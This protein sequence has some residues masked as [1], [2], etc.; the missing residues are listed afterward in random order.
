MK[1]RVYLAG[2]ALSVAA[3]AAHADVSV[4]PTVVS[5]YDFRGYSQSG[6]NPALQIGADYI[7]GPIH[8]GAWTSNVDFGPHDAKSELDLLA[9]YTFGSDD[10]VKFNT[11]VVYYMYPGHDVWTYPEAWVTAS[12]GWFSL[13]YAYSWAW[14]GTSDEASYIQGN[15]TVPIGETGFGVAGHVGYSFGQYWSSY[16]YTD[17]SLGVTKSFGNFNVA[18]KYVGSDQVEI[19]SDVFNN[20]DRVLLSVSTT[21]PWAKEKE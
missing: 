18:L 15:V 3:V 2:L 10:T 14:S 17:W 13:G 4:T 12:R 21:L 19:T 9:D 5:D 16:E 6:K 8:I 20:Q 11:G 1:S 7:S